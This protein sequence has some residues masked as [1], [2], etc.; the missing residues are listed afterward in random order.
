MSLLCTGSAH[1]HL[2]TIYMQT[3]YKH[4]T[5]I[6]YVKSVAIANATN[7]TTTAPLLFL[8][9]IYVLAS[10]YSWVG[11]CPP[12]TLFSH[13]HLVLNKHFPRDFILFTFVQLIIFLYAK[14]SFTFSQLQFTHSSLHFFCLRA[15]NGEL[16]RTQNEVV[17][18]Q[19]RYSTGIFLDGLK[20]TKRILS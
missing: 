16:D 3:K 11:G 12:L 8:L 17:M 6:V 4:T 7:T 2:Q 14:S 18:A 9:S 15:F 20:K 19:F 10:N 1:I 13:L 5:Y